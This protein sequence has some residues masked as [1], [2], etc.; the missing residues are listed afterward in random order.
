MVKLFEGIRLQNRET[1]KPQT[2]YELIGTR[3]QQVLF[4]I[5]S[6]VDPGPL[7]EKVRLFAS[8]FVFY[9]ENMVQMFQ[10]LLMN[11]IYNILIIVTKVFC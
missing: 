10:N 8:L 4:K 2:R 7:N 1:R 9:G 5:C 3:R 6:L 11:E